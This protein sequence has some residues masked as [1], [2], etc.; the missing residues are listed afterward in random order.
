M[1]KRNAVYLLVDLDFSTVQRSARI[2]LLGSLI[3]KYSI[4]AGN[5]ICAILIFID[6]LRFIVSHTK[7]L[8]A[9][10]R[11]AVQSHARQQR[12]AGGTL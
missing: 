7:L 8:L 6:R 4:L 10:A 11:G 2:S 12:A 1:L 3:N 9:A 5:S